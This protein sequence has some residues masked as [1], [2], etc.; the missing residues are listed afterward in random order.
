[1]KI[2]FVT[3]GVWIRTLLLAAIPIGVL[4]I[5]YLVMFQMPGSSFNGTPPE[6]TMIETESITHLEATV[7]TLSV[8]IGIRNVDTH[9]TLH[10]AESYLTDQLTQYGYEVSRLPYLVTE[11]NSLSKEVAN[12]EV[13]LTGSLLPGEIIVIGAHYDSVHGSMGADDNAS[14]AAALLELAR[15]MQDYVPTRTIRFVFFVNEEPPHFQTESMGSL[16]YAESCAARSDAIVAMLAI[17]SIGYFDSEAGSQVYPFPFNLLYPDTGNF[18][19]FVGDL[20]SR[21]LVR[22][23]IS[24]FRANANFPSEGVAS[25]ASIA[26]IGWSDHWSFWQYDYPAIMVTDT[27]PF[28]NPHYHTDMDTID[29]LDFKAMT[30][31]THG[32]KSV[33][34]YLDSNNQ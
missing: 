14:G 24:V 31:I 22:K 13:E 3:K 4:I 21:S 11:S 6:L 33:I 10:N 15:L 27:A 28:R 20:G 29:T 9:T 17:E 32:I 25:P 1:M 5:A 12:I 8:D 19:A 26:G 23:S 16:V 7:R 18:I 30:R 34:E 2:L